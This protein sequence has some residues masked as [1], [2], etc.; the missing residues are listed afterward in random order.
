[1]I[2]ILYFASLREQLDKASEQLECPI[3]VRNIGE[4]RAHLCERGAHWSQV[5]NANALVMM[6]I[7]HAMADA[8]ASIQ[9][10]DEIAFFPP[11][12]GG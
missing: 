12:T 6:S 11:V 7:N 4:L 5:L 2:T 8:S 9:E 3:G 1:M 10:G